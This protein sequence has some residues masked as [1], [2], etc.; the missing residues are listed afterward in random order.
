MCQRTH[1]PLGRITKETATG[2]EAATPDRVLGYDLEGHLTSASAPTGTNTYTYSARGTLSSQTARGAQPSTVQFD[3]FDRMTA[4]GP[5]TYAYDALDR[6][7][8]SGA[9]AFTYDGGSNNQVSDGT[10]R[11]TRTPAGILLATAGTTGTTGAR[12]EITDAH[13]D[14]VA[15]LDPTTNTL[16][17]S[18]AYDPFGKP[19]AKTGTTGTLG[20]QSAWTDP[21][22]G[23]V[24]M[25][26][27]WYQP[28]TGTFTSRDSWTLNPEPSIQGNR[29]TYA[30]GDPLDRTD[31]SGHIDC[32]VAANAARLAKAM[33]QRKLPLDICKSFN[34]EKLVEIFCSR[35]VIKCP[36]DSG[37]FGG[38]ADEPTYESSGGGLKCNVSASYRP[39]ACGKGYSGGG[40]GGGTKTKPHPAPRT[41]VDIIRKPVPDIRPTNDADRP[42]AHANP[43]DW[44]IDTAVAIGVPIATGLTT[45]FSFAASLAASGA[46]LL[47]TTLFGH[48][49][50]SP[51]TSPWPIPLPYPGQGGVVSTRSRRV[52]TCEDLKPTGAEDLKDGGWVEY[53]PKDILGRNKGVVSCLENAPASARGQAAGGNI[54]GWEEAKKEAKD[55]GFTGNVLARCHSVPRMAG[56][57]R[58]RR[59][60]TPCF[61]LG[62]N[63]NQQSDGGVITNT[64][65]S[66]EER[67]EAVM[68][69]GPVMYSVDINYQGTSKIPDTWN[70]GFYGW[71]ADNGLP[72]SS[73]QTV[74]ENSR[75]HP[76]RHSSIFGTLACTGNAGG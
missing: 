24:D 1:D 33:K 42:H 58:D 37:D 55:L 46:G 18:T 8:Q 20:Y 15:T 76:R 17:S 53:L 72:T 7:T 47:L 28:G 22:T 70:M 68:P 57:T 40:G 34:R 27:R 49:Q 75:Y 52:P 61:Q 69:Q 21:T 44:L 51:T 6:V 74:V 4:R 16:T 60:L 29:Y 54:D 14:V 56:E 59:N 13:T 45:G 9:T 32:S 65:R 38:F 63:I 66:F 39:A 71:R 67:A 19:T 64:M 41:P 31:P 26:A 5:V 36:S 30:S 23:D 35:G 73:G 25:A 48:T 11:Y 2:A 50:S 43:I 10:S 12:L 62:A 3:G